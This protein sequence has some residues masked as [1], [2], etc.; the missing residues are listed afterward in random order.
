MNL[1][2]ITRG[3]SQPLEGT[4]GGCTAGLPSLQGLL[5]NS[6]QRPAVQLIC[7]NKKKGAE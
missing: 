5:Q 6:P 2:E 3:Y 4:H 1:G 7:P